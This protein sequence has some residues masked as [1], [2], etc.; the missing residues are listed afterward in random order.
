MICQK[1]IGIKYNF[2]SVIIV[3][4]DIF[5][6]YYYFYVLYRIRMFGIKLLHEEKTIKQ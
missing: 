1:Y 3:Y 2:I 6:F 4:T 5:L